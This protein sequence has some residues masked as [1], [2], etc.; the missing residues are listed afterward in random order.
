MQTLD[1][2]QC[3]V[4]VLVCTNEKDAPKSHCKRVGGQDFFMRLK[5]K[6]KETGLI[7]TH[8]ATRTGCLGFCNDVGTTVTIYASGKAPRWY[9]EV[10]AEDFDFIW[11][12]IVRE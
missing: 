10:T 9:N 2:T 1:T 4:H 7:A 3:K 11:N 6:L 5:T 8:W 12:E